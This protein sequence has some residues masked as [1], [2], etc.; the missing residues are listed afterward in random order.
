MLIDSQNISFSTSWTNLPISSKLALRRYIWNVAHTEDLVW[1][2]KR[3]TSAKST[4]S[5]KKLAPCTESCSASPQTSTR[6]TT[7]TTPAAAA[8]AATASSRCSTESRHVVCCGVCNR[9]AEFELVDSF[10]VREERILDDR[11]A[12][13]YN[14]V[15]GPTSNVSQSSTPLCS[16]CGL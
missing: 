14:V 5:Y 13:R 1:G 6:T 4:T 16:G 11:A 7:K 12:N 9:F 10:K 8:E 2:A 15:P 3:G